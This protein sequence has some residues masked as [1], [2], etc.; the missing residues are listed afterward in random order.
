MWHAVRR[1]LI[2]S[3]GRLSLC[4]SCTRALNGDDEMVLDLD[5]FREDKGGDP[6]K[7]RQ[8]QINRFK[9]PSY[10]D[11]VV[12]ADTKWRKCKLHNS[13]TCVDIVS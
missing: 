9:D 12:E 1:S 6:E 7:I 11:R 2:H 13:Y 10:V 3:K 5:L 4:T 8:N